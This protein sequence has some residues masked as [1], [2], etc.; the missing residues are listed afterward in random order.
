MKRARV[1]QV[2]VADENN[3]VTTVQGGRPDVYRR[4]PCPKCPWRKDAVGEFPA[5]A[6]RLSAHT[7]YDMATSSFACHDSG[8]EKP[9]ACAGF[10][11][12]GASHNLGVR[13]RAFKG[14]IDLDQVD[15]GGH[16]LFDSYRAMAIAN[17]VDSNDPALRRCRA[18]HD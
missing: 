17:G 16:E 4:Q 9:A 6:F 15:D 7:A 12:R 14:E 8:A 11:L 18:N 1:T 2:R 10:L 3:V 13:M 5:E